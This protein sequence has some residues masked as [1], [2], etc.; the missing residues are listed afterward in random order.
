MRLGITSKDALI[1]VAVSV[2]YM[3]VL[4]YSIPAILGDP[5]DWWKVSAVEMISVIIWNQ[6][7]HAC[8]VFLAAAAAALLIVLL[9]PHSLMRT[10]WLTALAILMIAIIESIYLAKT[11]PWYR[12]LLASLWQQKNVLSALFIFDYIKICGGV[13]LLVW[14][15][16]R[17]L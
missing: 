12:L 8:V 16:Q 3:A 4:L 13:P 6:L 17:K 1:A 14:L 7:I 5:P 11:D 10:A 9:K 15:V 2:I